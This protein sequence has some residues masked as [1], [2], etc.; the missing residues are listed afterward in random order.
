MTAARL[1]PLVWCL[2]APAADPDF[3]W[4]RIG[5]A[6]G[7]VGAL[8]D[9]RTI[10]TWGDRIQWTPLDG[11]GVRTLDVA[12]SGAAL[13]DVN[14]DGRTDLVLNERSGALAWYEAPAWKRREIDTGVDAPDILA[15]TLLGRHGALLIHKRAEVRFYEAPRD[16]AGRWQ[17]RDLYSIYTPS[18][19]GGLAVGDVDGDGRDDIFCGNYWIRA[20]ERWVLPWRLFAINTWTED[21]ASG[22][23]RLAVERGAG[24]MVSAQRAL[25]DGRVGWFTRPANPRDQWEAR[26]VGR[27]DRPRAVL[28]GRWAIVAEGGGA[29][30]VVTFTPPD[31]A[32]RELR[33]GMPA[34][35]LVATPPGVVLVTADGVEYG[36][37]R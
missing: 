11:G 17:S 29:G 26:V 16:P 30:R 36:A 31:F 27:F 25:E 37:V 24:A 32:P 7:A 5:E 22:M 19:Q 2:A 28:L 35:A 33:R 23:M 14:R 18:W 4:K 1:L 8:A 6:A 12:A 20:P 34:V 21:E 9:G 13:M 15:A 3:V 10:V